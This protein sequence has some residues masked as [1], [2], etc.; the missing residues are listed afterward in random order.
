MGI[1]VSHG[2]NQYGEERRSATTIANLGK[3]LAHVLPSGDWRTIAFLFDGKVRCPLAV[4]PRKALK[5]AG[6]LQRAAVNPLMPRDWAE[7][8]QAFATAARRAATARQPWEWS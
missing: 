4:P 6:V 2:A 1:N 8:A 7:D 5:I 3:Q